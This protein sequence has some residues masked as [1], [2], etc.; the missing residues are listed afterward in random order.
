MME[1]LPQRTLGV[2]LFPR[3]DLLDVAGPLQVFG[4]LKNLF[5]L[6]L[7]AEAA[8]PV[9]SGQGPAIVAD[10]AAARCPRL[11]VL[12][13]PGGVGVRERMTNEAF[14][15]WLRERAEAAEIVLS[16]GTGAALLA[17]AG[18]LDGRRATSNKRGLAWVKEQGPRVQWVGKAR[19]VDEGKFVTASGAAAGIDMALHLVG[20]LASPER[21]REVRRYIQY[22]PE[23]P[24]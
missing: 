10:V 18:L 17:K 6:L 3:F 14:L 15:A 12:L 22:D 19:W 11:E 20:R 1:D 7:I 4:L 2:A 24:Y 21:A 23:P 5:E 8:G 16:V 13:V 9:E